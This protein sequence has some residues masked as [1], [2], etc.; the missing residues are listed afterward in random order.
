MRTLVVGVGNEDRGDDGA[1]P[2][3]AR[4]LRA[5]WSGGMPAGVEVLVWSGDP[6]GLL[7]RLT[8][9]DRLLLVDAVVTGAPP[10][11][12]HRLLP[13]APFATAPAASS[14]GLGLAEALA[15]GR[16]L[17]RLP[18]HVE[19]WGVEGAAFD[20]G[21]GLHE[22]VRRGVERVVDGLLVQKPWSSEQRNSVSSE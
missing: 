17:G 8:G 20:L 1:G 14:H 13:D 18:P 9:V 3:A 7:D 16:A 12:I 5:A 4:L 21:T 15:L 2:Y 10:G 22:V 11:T 19:V 6:L